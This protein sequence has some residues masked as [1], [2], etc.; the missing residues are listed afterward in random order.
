MK[1]A[2]TKSVL[3]IIAVWGCTARTS[4]GL[5]KNEQL[6]PRLSVNECHTV[7]LLRESGL[8]AAFAEVGAAVLEFGEFLQ[9][10]EVYF[11]GGSVSL[12]SDD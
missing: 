4:D 8:V 6:G 3:R 7:M 2:A 10:D 9:K 11:S 5:I 1:E 12:F